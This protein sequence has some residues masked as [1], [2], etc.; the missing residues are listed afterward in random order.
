VLRV[1]GNLD[2]SSLLSIMFIRYG[3]DYII[4]VPDQNPFLVCK[5]G[6]VEVARRN[7]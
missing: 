3:L 1:E 2:Y 7:V 5:A 4:T 6:E